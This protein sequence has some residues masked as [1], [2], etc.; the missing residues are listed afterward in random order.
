[1]LIRKLA[2]F[3]DPADAQIGIERPN[4]GLIR[5]IYRCRHDDQPCIPNLHGA[6]QTLRNAA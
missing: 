2:R 1:M 4:G 6:A 3:D 5:V